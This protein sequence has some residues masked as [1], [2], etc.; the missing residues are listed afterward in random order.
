MFLQLLVPYCLLIA[1]DII[2][3]EVVDNDDDPYCVY[4]KVNDELCDNPTLSSL[5]RL[6]L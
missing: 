1:H 2:I 4:R 5:I 6:L 3:L